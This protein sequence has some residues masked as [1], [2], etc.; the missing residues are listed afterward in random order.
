MLMLDLYFLALLMR[1]PT[2]D[3][4]YNAKSLSDQN[5][6]LRTFYILSG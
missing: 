3:R 4:Q 2:C 5:F 6:D 1:R